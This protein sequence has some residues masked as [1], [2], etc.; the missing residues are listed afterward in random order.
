MG[1]P[2]LQK[3]RGFIS[4]P[5]HNRT[6][7]VLALL[8]IATAIPLTVFVASQQQQIREHAAQPVGP[9]GE[10]MPVGDLSGWKQ[11][12]TDDFTTDVAVGGFSGCGTANAVASTCSGL[13][14]AVQA[15]W[16]AY[17]ETWH[18]TT[19][20]GAYTPSQVISISGGVMNLNIH[21]VN[22]VHMVAAPVPKLPGAVGSEGGLQYGR[23]AVRFKADSVAG[24]KTAW[25]LWPDSENQPQNG[26]IDFPEGNLNGNI[27]AFMHWA[28][29]G[30]SQDAY[31]TKTTY[32]AWHTAVTE[33][34]PTGITFYL[35]GQV[36]GTSTAHIPNTPMHWVIQTETSTDGTV[37]SSTAAGN[38]QI[39][40]VA[41][42]S[43]APGLVPGG[44]PTITPASAPAP[45][46]QIKTVFV[47]LMESYSWSSVY[48]SSSAPYIN[49][50][51]LPQA[52]YATNYHQ[53]P[54]N[55][56]LSEPQYIWTEAGNDLGMTTDNDPS[57]SNS[58]ATTDHLVTYLDRAGIPWKAYE[59]NI[60]GTNC[61]ISNTGQYLVRHEPFIFF[62]NV[63]STNA[64]S[65]VGAPSSSSAYC[66]QHLRPYSE[67]A[68]DLA[69][70]A[71]SGYNF[72]TPN[73]CNDMHDNCTGDQVNQGDTWLKNNI[74]TIMNSQAYKNGGAIFITWDNGFSTSDPIGMIVLS[75]LAKGNGYSNA[76]NYDHSSLLK[77]VE[78]IF[79]LSPLLGNAANATTNSL[80]DLFGTSLGGPIPT[81]GSKP[82]PT[83]TPKPTSSPPPTVGS[84]LVTN[85]GCETNTNGWIGWQGTVSRNT[86]VAHSGSA[87]CNVQ[88]TSGSVYTIDDNPDSVSNP[89]IGQQYT[90]SAWVRSDTAVGKEAWVAITL[91][92]GAHANKTIYSPS[93]VN[94]STSWQQ[95]TNTV[96][97]DYADRTSLGVYV[98]EDPAVSGK[99]SFQTDDISLRLVNTTNTHTWTFCANEG[100]WCSFTG[101]KNVRYGAN[102]SYYYKTFTN[103]TSCTNVVFG[104]PLYG[105]KKQCYY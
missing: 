11:I 68:T 65:G 67:L 74:P 103:G 102:G 39:D 16:W 34:T 13:P 61:P 45:T 101:I 62:Q 26:E 32:S 17:P 85:P 72:L 79:N 95:L 88:Q 54:D 83:S 82:T 81:S 90:A 40:W 97:V 36:I 69:N 35:D 1:N 84:S 100:V 66:M 29:G 93:H 20:N 24:Y 70:N 59:E 4:V 92:G 12:F 44:S 25:L 55:T 47:I 73:S 37:P 80:S 15:K 104:D 56:N 5:S 28:G 48:Q 75:P 78:Q 96:S 18:D 51:L 87:S 94:L 2:F 76:I 49:N 7:S 89:Q 21:T 63:S 52:S 53:P 57:L 23:Y 19:G 98:A 27:S 10:A 77:T 71:V 64:P 31:P 6:I 33:W 58:S 3:V 30:G 38:V 8:I 99:D 50:T 91:K 43:Y 105:T 60:P 14:A 41:A 42:W 86:S 9:S 46:S 22:G